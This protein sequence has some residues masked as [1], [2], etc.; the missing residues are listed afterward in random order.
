MKALVLVAVLAVA[1][2]WAWWEIRRRRRGQLVMPAG[3]GKLPI[4]RVVLMGGPWDGEKLPVGRADDV[5]YVRQG[6]RT[7]GQYDR[8]GPATFTWHPAE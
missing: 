2:Y 7:S 3:T 6:G 8:V 4:D 1:C 5:I